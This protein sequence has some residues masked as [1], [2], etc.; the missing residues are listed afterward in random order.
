L[1][2]LLGS[3]SKIALETYD[4][5]TIMHIDVDGDTHTDISIA[6]EGHTGLWLPNMISDGIS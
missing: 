4:I 1:S 3:T 6:L 2:D 5:V